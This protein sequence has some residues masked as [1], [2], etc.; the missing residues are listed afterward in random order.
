MAITYKVLHFDFTIGRVPEW[1][2]LEI[3]LNAAGLQDWHLEGTTVLN[4]GIG[5]NTR[6]LILFMK[7]SVEDASVSG[8]TGIPSG[9]TFGS[10]VLRLDHRLF[11]ASGIGSGEAFGL[12]RLFPQAPPRTLTR[13]AGIPSGEAFSTKGKV[14]RN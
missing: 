8:S 11:S 9:E 6:S 12:G 2:A 3:I 4:Y 1:D 14:T 13:A 10:G 7:K 5:S